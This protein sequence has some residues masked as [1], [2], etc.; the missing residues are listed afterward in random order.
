MRRTIALGS[1]AVLLS[2]CFGVATN[3]QPG[4]DGGAPDG[5]A[6]A[7]SDAG[8]DARGD[9]GSADS[10]PVDSGVP[11]IYGTNSEANGELN[12]CTLLRSGGNR[13]TAYN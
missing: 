5:G 8:F 3:N 2:G 13:L 1:L 12:R 7:A 11:L 9:A 10:G 4:D 6:D